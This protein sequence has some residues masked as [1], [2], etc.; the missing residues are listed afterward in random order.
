[1]S[2]PCLAVDKGREQR[3]RSQTGL[4]YRSRNRNQG[5][6]PIKGP[7]QCV[8]LV[9][10]QFVVGTALKI[11]SY[12]NTKCC[13]KGL[14]VYLFLRCMHSYNT[15]LLLYPAFVLLTWYFLQVLFYII[16]CSI[17]QSRCKFTLWN[18]CFDYKSCTRCYNWYQ[19]FKVHAVKICKVLNRNMLNKH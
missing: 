19:R 14:F 10:G 15:A 1:M 9:T 7:Q 3:G 18:V 8:P 17:I 16:F 12:H 5:T 4:Q 2:S 11:A 6:H 13:I